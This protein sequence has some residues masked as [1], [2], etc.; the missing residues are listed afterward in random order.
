MVS[1]TTELI[2]SNSLLLSLSQ[3]V[4]LVLSVTTDSAL[5]SILSKN[6][7]C[8]LFPLGPLLLP[9]RREIVQKELSVYGKKL[10]ESAFNNQV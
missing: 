2:Y 5:R 8:M 9:D 1:K 4:C 10:S 6:T 3:G 7:S